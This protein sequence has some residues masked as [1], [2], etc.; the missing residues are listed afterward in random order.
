MIGLPG[1]RHDYRD[2]VR[3]HNGRFP[4]PPIS[5]CDHPTWKTN[6]AESLAQ[7][8]R[9][10]R[11]RLDRLDPGIRTHQCQPRRRADEAWSMA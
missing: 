10:R 2:G 1:A 7:G 8:R 6:D 11:P 5:I 9:H 3:L 4:L